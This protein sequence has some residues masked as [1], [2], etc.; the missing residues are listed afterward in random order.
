MRATAC[1][2]QTLA[3]AVAGFKRREFQ[4]PASAISPRCG[5]RRGE[6]GHCHHCLVMAG[7][8]SRP[9]HCA[10]PRSHPTAGRSFVGT[11]RRLRP[12]RAGK[13]AKSMTWPA[14]NPPWDPPVVKYRD[15]APGRRRFNP[16]DRPRDPRRERELSSIVHLLRRRCQ[17]TAKA[18]NVA[19]SR[20]REFPPTPP[21]FD[22]GVASDWRGRCRYCTHDQAM[23]RA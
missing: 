18:K 20:P 12:E 2:A 15:S 6:K 21:I 10:L 19:F 13:S 4:Q 8:G 3:I 5:R 7:V 16:R 11:P 1:R 22:T 17:P 9:G 14:F 23:S